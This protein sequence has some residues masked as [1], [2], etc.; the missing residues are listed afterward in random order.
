MILLPISGFFLSKGL[1]FEGSKIHNIHCATIITFSLLFKDMF[2]Y[3]DG[4]VGAAI[5]AVVLVHVVIAIFI[6]VAWNEGSTKVD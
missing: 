5:V 1:V 6:Y 3:A 2:G 4:S